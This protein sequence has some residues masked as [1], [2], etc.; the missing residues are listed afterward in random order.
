M[1]EKIL[2]PGEVI[3]MQGECAYCGDGAMASV[4]AG[5]V[6]LTDKRLFICKDKASALSIILGIIFAVI[7]FVCLDIFVGIGGAIGGAISGAVG[8]GLGFFVANVL[9]KGKKKQ[10]DK[11]EYSFERA[12]IESVEDG[13]RGVQK[14]L[15]VKT[16]SGQICKF[17]PNEKD[18]KEK[19]R[20]AL[21]NVNS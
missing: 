16:K 15:V 18:S 11:A 4:N 6:V 13:N 1:F 12:N 10:P 17:N 3:E 21:T 20:A 5:H 14:M 19:W 2:E 7:I 9:T 8:F